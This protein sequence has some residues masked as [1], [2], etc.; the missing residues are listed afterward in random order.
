MRQALPWPYPGAGM[1]VAIPFAHH[2][3]QA[4]GHRLDRREAESF[5]QVV[6]ERAKQ[7]SG[8]PNML[9]H[10]RLTASMKD[11]M[12]E[13]GKGVQQRPHLPQG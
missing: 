10:L 11:Q 9:R 3:M 12:P 6:R 8:M 13:A 5:L 7:M 1:V 2:H 4:R